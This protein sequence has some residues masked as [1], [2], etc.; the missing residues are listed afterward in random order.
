MI[1]SGLTVLLFVLMGSSQGQN[2]CPPGATWTFAYQD[3]L[4]GVIGHARV[5]HTLDTLLAGQV[6]QRLDIRVNAYSYPTQSYWTEQPGGVLFTT[7]TSDIVQL[8]D[9]NEE[10][11]DTLYW[12]SALPGDHWSV[13][14]TYGSVPD[15]LV[16][17]TLHS[18]IDGL[19]LRQ[20][21]VGLDIA[22][23]EP[24]DT[25][26]ERLGFGTIFIDGISPMF[27]VDQP[28]G[29][30]RCY[31]DVDIMW[32][33]PH[34]NFGCN[35]ILNTNS[36]PTHG[37]W[38]IFPNP[39]TDHLTLSLSPG[40]YNVALFDAT[41]RTVLQEQVLG[42]PVVIGTAQLP[43]GVYVVRVDDEVQPMRWVKE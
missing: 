28:I 23:P 1:R 35:S 4:G 7:G 14:W 2:W 12:F 16:L 27:L 38:H 8:W 10:Q 30:L 43:S 41:G 24:I 33:N 20:V 26:T 18:V 5:D 29:G 13:P 39:G 37:A 31:S 32:S 22:S 15:L 6:A 19:V 17:D 9:P 34:W 36:I 42:F 25:L 11:F 40:T 21:V 3:I